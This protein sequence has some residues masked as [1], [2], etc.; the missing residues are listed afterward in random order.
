MNGRKI[1]DEKVEKGK[2]NMITK[3]NIKA[4]EQKRED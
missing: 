3:W 4:T 1:G 2:E